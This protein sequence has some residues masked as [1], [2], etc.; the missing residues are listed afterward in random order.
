ML[1][2]GQQT[3]DVCLLVA[4]VLLYPLAV[5]LGLNDGLV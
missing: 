5:L 3:E 4:F 2:V 1:P